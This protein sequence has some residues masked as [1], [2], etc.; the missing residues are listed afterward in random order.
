MATVPPHRNFC[1]LIAQWL[2]SSEFA[3]LPA[4]LTAERQESAAENGLDALQRAAGSWSDDPEGL[5]RFLEWNRQQRKVKR[6]E[7]PE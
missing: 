4:G 7:L 5:D 2:P 3:A 6:R 1:L